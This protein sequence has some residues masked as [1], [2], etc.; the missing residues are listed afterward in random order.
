MSVPRTKQEINKKA[1]EDNQTMSEPGTTVYC[2][3]SSYVLD[4]SDMT[5][6]LD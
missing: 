6:L 2:T 4:N 3:K 5:Y 1:G